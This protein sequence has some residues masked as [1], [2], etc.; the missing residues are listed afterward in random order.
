MNTINTWMVRC[1]VAQTVSNGMYAQVY[2]N[3]NYTVW[4]LT[5]TNRIRRAT[6]FSCAWSISAA[7]R[8]RFSAW[9]AP[10]AVPMLMLPRVTTM[11]AR[12]NSR[13]P[14]AG[15]SPAV[16][17]DETYK[18]VPTS[19]GF[20][21]IYSTNC[22]GYVTI[23]PNPDGDAQGCFPLRATTDDLTQ[24][25]RFYPFGTQRPAVID[26][27]DVCQNASGLSFAGADIAGRNLT[28][29]V[30]SKCDMTQ[31]AG[32]ENCVL[33]GANL[34]HANLSGVHLATVSMSG[35]D[36]SNATLIGT[37][38]RSVKPWSKTPILDGA[39]LTNAV[40]PSSLAG[41]SMRGAT[42]TGVNLKGVNLAGA[43]LTNADLR[44]AIVAG[45]VL[46]AAKLINAR[47]EGLNL[48]GVHITQ[49]NLTGAHLAGC[50]L[51][52]VDLTG[53]ILAGTDF[54]GVD[55]TT[56]TMPCPLRGRPIRAR[57]PFSQMP[58]CPT[59]RSGWTGPI[60]TSPIPKSS[61]CLPTLRS[62][63]RTGESGRLLVQ[64]PHS[65]RSEL[66]QRHSDECRFR[67]CDPAREA[68]LCRREPG[69][70]GVHVRETRRSQL[71]R[72][73]ARRCDG[74]SRDRVL[75]RVR[76]QLRLHSGRYVR[77]RLRGRDSHGRQQAER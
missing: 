39:N 32:L 7:G 5:P 4:G 46:T 15:G 75:L 12:C 31:V 59:R 62:E 37:D 63:R 34:Q 66:H 51:P 25:A 27:L 40:L 43:D 21:A 13:L 70:G 22:N 8:W 41:A 30:L 64:V 52:D 69:R 71:C 47:L 53:T 11:A 36:L 14:T 76:Q 65:E 49:A 44:G 58:G 45:G 60:S 42:L 55:L 9:A 20:F 33:D 56:T 74:L 26:F 68:G 18:I 73:G 57:R 16:G 54:T 48:E 50:K 35:T 77:R 17:G 19:D 23:N 28:G 24:A 61:D 2:F 38:F 3:Q 67:E 10:V 1:D 6:G 72:R 29:F